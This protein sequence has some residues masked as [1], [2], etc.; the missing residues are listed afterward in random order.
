MLSNCLRRSLASRGERGEAINSRAASIARALSSGRLRVIEVKA[1]SPPS[2]SLNEIP[3]P[4]PALAPAKSAQTILRRSGST[5][6]G[7]AAAPST[8]AAAGG[9]SS[10]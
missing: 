5:G 8:G 3:G 2:R 1:R 4:S 10:N 6:T 7:A 9:I